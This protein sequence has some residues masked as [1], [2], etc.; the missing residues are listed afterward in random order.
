MAIVL[1]ALASLLLL[2]FMPSSGP[3]STHFVFY[4]SGLVFRS[5]PKTDPSTYLFNKCWCSIWP[6]TK[7]GSKCLMWINSLIPHTKS[8]G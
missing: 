5:C 8:K 6:P 2:F 7:E 4:P 1:G 3:G